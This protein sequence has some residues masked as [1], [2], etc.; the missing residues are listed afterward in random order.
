MWTSYNNNKR[1]IFDKYLY[2]CPFCRLSRY[3]VLSENIKDPR[4]HKHELYCHNCNVVFSPA[5]SVL[6]LEFNKEIV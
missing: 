1:K 6:P 3:I 4:Y 2:G 5:H